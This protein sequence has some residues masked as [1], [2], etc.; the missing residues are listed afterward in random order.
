MFISAMPSRALE[1]KPTYTG[2]LGWLLASLKARRMA[3]GIWSGWDSST[4]HLVTGRTSSAR[5]VMVS[6]TLRTS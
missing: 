2:P 6:L 5:S 3:L 1:V 4:D